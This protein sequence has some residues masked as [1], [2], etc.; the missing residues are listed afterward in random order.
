M[1]SPDDIEESRSHAFD[2]K[3]LTALDFETPGAWVK[4]TYQLH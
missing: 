1:T 2:D 4:L 3:E